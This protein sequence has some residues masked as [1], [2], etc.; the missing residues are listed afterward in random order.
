MKRP[1]QVPVSTAKITSK[2]KQ[3]VSAFVEYHTS[4]NEGITAQFCGNY[5]RNAVRENYTRSAVRKDYPG[6]AV[7]D[8]YPES[9]V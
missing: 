2:I 8:D 9:A 5:I 7:G 1:S 4:V 3:T 6:S